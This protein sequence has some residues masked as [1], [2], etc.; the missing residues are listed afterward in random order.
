MKSFLRASLFCFAWLHL[1][2]AGCD[3][4]PAKVD[5]PAPTADEQK[6][7]DEVGKVPGA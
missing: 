3:S 2:L 6:Q 4:E 7:M 5:A 1:L